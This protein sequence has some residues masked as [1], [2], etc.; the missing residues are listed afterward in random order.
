MVK[1]QTWAAIILASGLSLSAIAPVIAEDLNSPSPTE[2]TSVNSNSE[3]IKGTIKSII[4]QL[5]IVE[6]ANGGT[7]TLSFSKEEIGT[8][9]LRPGM[10]LVATQT[11]GVTVID[12]VSY[13][14]ATTSESSTANRIL[15]LKAPEVRMETSS[16]TTTSGSTTTYTNSSTS[17][18][19]SVETSPTPATLPA[20]PRALW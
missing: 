3:S 9:N 10:Y 17:V 5:V 6:L 14:T 19:N 4:G 11:N 16:E 7:T 1:I 15:N 2:S 18:D 20:T 13:A 8:Y 12:S